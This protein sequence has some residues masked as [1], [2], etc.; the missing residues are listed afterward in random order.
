MPFVTEELWSHLGDGSSLIVTA[1]WPEIPLAT[2]PTEM[3]SLQALVAGIRQFRSQHQIGRKI[4]IPVAVVPSDERILPD[5]WYAQA[6]SLTG[7][8]PVAGARPEPISG[9][10]RISSPGA[11]AFISLDGLV[12]V[13]E[14]KPRIEKAIADLES[15][16]AQA[17]AKLSNQ[18]FRERAP[19]EV[20]EETETRLVRMEAELDKQR[21][22]L[23]D[24]G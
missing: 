18:N 12:D 17:T 3:E 15:G 7:A 8:I 16:I 22:H 2:A 24:V 21:Q 23:A 11:E 5:W 10:T 9:Y 4:E 6:A 19:A 14:E 13:E 1:A 20:V